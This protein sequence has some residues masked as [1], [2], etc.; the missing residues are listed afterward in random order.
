M[1]G[2]SR[3]SSWRGRSGIIAQRSSTVGKLREIAPGSA[4]A[5]G[6]VTTSTRSDRHMIH[7]TRVVPK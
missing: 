7:A 2:R 4:I 1:G 3:T 6:R 5:D